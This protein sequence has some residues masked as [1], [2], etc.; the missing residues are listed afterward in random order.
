MCSFWLRDIGQVGTQ[1]SAC[2]S[3]WEKFPMT[4]R[5][6]VENKTE[7]EQ[8]ITVRG[9]FRFHV[10]SLFSSISSR[11]FVCTLS[12]NPCILLDR[13]RDKSCSIVKGFKERSSRFPKWWELA[14]FYYPCHV[15]EA[16]M[17]MK[18]GIQMKI[19]EERRRMKRRDRFPSCLRLP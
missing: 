6:E 10:F 12:N 18:K 19:S 8:F 15:I 13:L 3:V 11:E 7:H 16:R 14:A 1:F 17:K 2:C 5:E 9:D 4:W